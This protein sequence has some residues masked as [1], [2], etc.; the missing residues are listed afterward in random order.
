MER[1]I[2]KS[3]VRGRTAAPGRLESAGSLLAQSNALVRIIL[4]LH[5]SSLCASSGCRVVYTASSAG[6]ACEVWKMLGLYEPMKWR[7]QMYRTCR[8]IPAFAK[9]LLCPFSKILPQTLPPAVAQD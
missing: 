6:G 9:V 4:Q 3:S 7:A 1:R 2:L 8:Q 5:L